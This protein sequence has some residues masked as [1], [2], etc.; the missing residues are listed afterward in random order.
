MNLKFYQIYFKDE[1]LKELYD[2]A[3]PHRNETCT[4]F[5]E[6]DVIKNLVPETEAKYICVASWRLK[7]K[8]LS[9]LCPIIL[10]F[11]LKDDLSEEKILKQDADIMN[12]R[13]FSPSH[14]MLHNAAAWHGG[15]KHN[16]SWDN[17]IAELKK[18]MHIPT[19]VNTP[20]YENHFI[21]R[22]E[23][24]HDYVTNCLHPVMQFMSGNSAFFSDSGYAE[25]KGRRE[26]SAVE[27]YRKETGRQDWPIAPFVLERLFSIW[28]N[29][30]NFKIV[31]V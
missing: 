20:I 17:A 5:F 15:Q 22:K 18:F 29:D 2:F 21:A 25:K 24:Y 9:G 16:Y 23:I 28:I 8:R 19:E 4:D 12:L 13:P 14:K 26:P 7:E 31:N 3:T 1:Q 10:K 6:N 11:H 27:Q 30:K